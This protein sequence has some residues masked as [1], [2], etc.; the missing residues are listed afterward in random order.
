M[1][2]SYVACMH[3]ADDLARSTLTTRTSIAVNSHHKGCGYQRGLIW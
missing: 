3:H 2:S 1:H